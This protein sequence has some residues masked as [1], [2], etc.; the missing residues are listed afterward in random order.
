MMRGAI[1]AAANASTADIHAYS[2]KVKEFH[3]L[4]HNCHFYLDGTSAS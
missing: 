2:Q 4:M 3:D 1:V